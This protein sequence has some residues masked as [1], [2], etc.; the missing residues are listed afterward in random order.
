[1]SDAST[2]VAGLP[3]YLAVVRRRKWLIALAVVL[4]PLAAVG[5]SLQQQKRYQASAEVLLS[6]QNLAAALTGTQQTGVN[7]QPDRIAQTQAEVAQVPAV[8]ARVLRAVPDTGLTITNFLDNA[9][10]STSPDADLLRFHVTNRDPALATR[11][12]NAY[13]AAYT[14]Y[15]RHLDTTSIANALAGVDRSLKT[16]KHDQRSPLYSSLVD[17]EQTLQTMQAL[18]T[19]NAAVVKQASRASQV[20]PK[21]VRN[22]ILGLALGVVLGIGLA[23]LREALDTR[24]RTADEI[25]TR[26]RL[27]LLGRLPAPPKRLR[28]ESRLVMLS[29]PSSPQAEPFRILRSNLELA[30]LDRD[31]KL[32][33]ITSGVHEEGKTTT[34]SNLAV[35]LARTGQRVILVDLDLRRPTVHQFFDLAGPGVTEV[36]LGRVSLAEALR[37]IAITTDQSQRR[38][39]SFTIQRRNGTSNG[40]GRP[41]VKGVLEVL[42]SGVLPPSPGEFV[43]SPSFQHMLDELRERADIVLI[44]TPP[45]LQVGDALTLSA[46]VDA[47]IVVTRM[48]VVRRHMLDELR[49]QLDAAPTAKLGFVLTAAREEEG[50][51]YGYD[52]GYGYG[53]EAPA[54]PVPEASPVGG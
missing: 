31:A 53:F 51:G 52:Y 42:P 27:P 26:L 19:S 47:L 29:A 14:A 13:A 45:L 8:A 21:P 28:A 40:N 25:G 5:F 17:R 37:P 36:A 30:R 46:R 11:L 12:V 41:E 54:S 10:V 48:S 20:Q 7:L 23:F 24:V 49:R 9:G 22:G 4:V 2:H 39:R 43:A 35:A 1:M 32:V 6:S 15:R 44:D 3:D 34:V 50:Y 38:S 16:L 33:M 18:Q